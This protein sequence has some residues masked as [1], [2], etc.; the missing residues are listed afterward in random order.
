M[1]ARP[2]G[3]K[4]NLFMTYIYHYILLTRKRHSTVN[5]LKSADGA[6]RKADLLSKISYTDP[7][8]F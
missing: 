6:G 7:A 2:V 4:I 8:I 3:V 1:P 5:P